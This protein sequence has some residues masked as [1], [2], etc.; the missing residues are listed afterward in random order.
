MRW[1]QLCLQLKVRSESG[2]ASRSVLQHGIINDNALQS[3][4]C[5]L[6]PIAWNCSAA[7]NALHTE[8]A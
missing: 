1:L 5:L 7:L 4:V 2:F 3:T 6:H 8:H